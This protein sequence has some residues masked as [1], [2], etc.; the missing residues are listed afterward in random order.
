MLLSDKNFKKILIIQTASIGDVILATPVIEKLHAN[1]PEARIDF[2]LRAGFE[3][4]LKGH[5]HVK[6]I[7]SWDKNESKYNNL[8]Q[9]LEHVRSERYDLVINLQRFFSTGLLTLF[10][11]A[12]V[13]IGFKKNPLSI[14]FTKR[15]G[16]KI[17]KK[18]AGIHEIDRNLALTSFINDHTRYMPKL[19]PGKKAYAKISQY[20]TRSYITISPVSIWYTKQF[21]VEKWIQFIDR[22]P[23]DYNIYLLG[24]KQDAQVTA[25]IIKQTNHPN[26]LDL[27]GQLNLQESAALIAGAAMNYANDSAAQHLASALNAPVTTIYCSTVPEFGFGPLSDDRAIIQTDEALDCRPCGLH[28]YNKCPKGH[29]KCAN[30][31]IDK[32]LKRLG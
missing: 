22:V 2:V 17:G 8:Y 6:A 13:K 26:V 25:P 4:L 14:W 23:E 29:F 5:P 7:I 30:I 18:Y 1:Y 11:G 3:P 31:D 21:P 24:S 10:S 27:S 9:I 15:V 20:R 19:Y 12:K 28:G 16:H 32:L